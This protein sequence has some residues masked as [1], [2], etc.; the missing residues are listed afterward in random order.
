MEEM[1]E[2]KEGMS[3]GYYAA[4]NTKTKKIEFIGSKT[5]RDKFIKKNSGVDYIRLLTGP[6]KKVGDTAK[7]P[8]EVDELFNPANPS[9][10][11]VNA[12]KP[13]AFSGT[14]TTQ[15]K[16]MK[17]TKKKIEKSTSKFSS[18]FGKKTKNKAHESMENI[19]EVKYK[20]ETEAWD[21][22]DTHHNE[23]RVVKTYPTYQKAIIAADKLN[24]QH[25]NDNLGAMGIDNGIVIPR[26]GVRLS[27]V[28]EDSIDSI[29]NRITEA[30]S[31]DARLKAKA[32][33]KRR[34]AILAK[35]RALS[36][37]K[38]ASKST[39]ERRATK[40]A[41]NLIMQKRIL[42]GRDKSMMSPSEKANI[43]KKMQAFEPAVQKLAK[44]MFTKVKAAGELRR[45]S[46]MKA[47]K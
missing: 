19:S 18:L 43:E 41:H 2:I 20:W 10:Y 38:T 28:K 30:L 1:E 9:A 40:A 3:G 24:S 15:T 4:V 22:I 16:K 7:M 34:A 42:H 47:K 21:V 36:V 46:A 14:H 33:M 23:I 44:K 31:M 17:D 29:L 8:N 5:G 12:Y 45:Q 32:D 35:K 37:R 6:G 11:G 27:V 39:I 13:G 26:F 25:S